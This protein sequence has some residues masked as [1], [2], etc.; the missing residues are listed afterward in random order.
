MTTYIEILN[1]YKVG[2][3]AGGPSNERRVSLRSGEAVSKA[4][5]SAGIDRVILLDVTE[6]DF[7]DIIHES[8]IDIAFIALHGRFGED[9]TV[10]RALEKME[11]PYT[12]SRPESSALALDKLSSR[13]HFIDN[14]LDAPDYMVVRR[15]QDISELDIWLPCVVKP[16]FEGSSIGLS[17]V[18][19]EA[20]LIA[21]VDKAFAFGE[22]VIIEKF[23]HGREITVGILAEK[24][25]PVVEI[26]AR[27]GVYDFEAKYEAETTKYIVP[28]ELSKKEYLLAQDTA[29]KAHRAIGCRGFSRV[30][31]RLS[32]EERMYVLE[33]NTIPGLTQRS[34]FPMAAEA[35][36]VDFPL[37][38]VIMLYGALNENMEIW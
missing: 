30:D 6:E 14:G 19:S 31:M 33:V 38:C 13:A 2:V 37:L 23:I 28:A 3:L 21:A 5:V 12:G 35:A 16:R 1:R 8:G 34:L 36:G 9:G 27:G 17:I 29:L 32:A 20:E 24:P 22:E 10:Q 26:E 25:L 18:K 4:L 7:D 15:G 11:I